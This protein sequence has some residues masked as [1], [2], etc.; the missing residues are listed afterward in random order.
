MRLARIG[1]ETSKIAH[2]TIWLSDLAYFD[3]VTADGTTGSIPSIRLCGPAAGRASQQELKVE[4]I[5]VA[6]APPAAR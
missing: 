2:I 6:W 1:S 5:V 4:M 3:E